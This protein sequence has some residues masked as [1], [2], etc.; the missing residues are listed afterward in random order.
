ML[1][2]GDIYPDG[3]G[4]YRNCCGECNH[5]D[6]YVSMAV[7]SEKRGVLILH[8]TTAVSFVAI[9]GDGRAVCQRSTMA[10]C[11]SAGR[12]SGWAGRN[13]QVLGALTLSLKNMQRPARRRSRRSP[14]AAGF[15]MLTGGFG[16]LPWALPTGSVRIAITP[17]MTTD[18]VTAQRALRIFAS[19]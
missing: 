15:D 17:A 16:K 12:G 4:C 11:P 19:R 10:V 8:P 13:V 3:D 14:F 9:N 18:I 2:I 6:F 5:H 7:G 1:Q